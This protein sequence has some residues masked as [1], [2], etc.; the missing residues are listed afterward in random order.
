MSEAQCLPGRSGHSATD[1]TCAPW[2][3]S[4]SHADPADCTAPTRSRTTLT[5]SC[6][7]VSRCVH[8]GLCTTHAKDL[9]PNLYVNRIFEAWDPLPDLGCTRRCGLDIPAGTREVFA[10]GLPDDGC[11]DTL[12][13]IA[14]CINTPGYAAYDNHVYNVVSLSCR[15]PLSSNATQVVSP[16]DGQ[17]YFHMAP[18]NFGPNTLVVAHMTLLTSDSGS[19]VASIASSVKQALNPDATHK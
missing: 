14:G 6:H 8:T 7:L 5:K 17:S 12:S 4:A 11:Y 3:T 10:R 2:C 18:I 13:C 1:T 15:T 9:L 16:L 19:Q